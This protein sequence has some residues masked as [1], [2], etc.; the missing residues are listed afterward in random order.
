MIQD[1]SPQ[2]RAAAP[3]IAAQ[4]WEIVTGLAKLVFHSLARN[5]ARIPI[6]TVVYLR[7]WHASR[8][9]T[10][11]ANALAAGAPTHIQRTRPKRDRKPRPKT[12]AIPQGKGWLL[13]DLKHEAALFRFRLESLLEDPAAAE[14]FASTPRAARILRPLCHMLAL[15]PPCLPP[16]KATARKPAKP[17]SPA[18]R[19]PRW[20]Y[21]VLPPYSTTSSTP[22]RIVRSKVSKFWG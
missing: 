22:W 17:K 3:D 1:L 11:L 6:I 15:D 7:I 21:P 10:T 14:I 9:F 5:P 19:K 16:L 18:Q 13:K 8:R 2:T 20:R 12:P 4:F